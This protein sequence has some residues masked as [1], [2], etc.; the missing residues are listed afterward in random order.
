[1]IHE[2]GHWMN[3]FKGLESNRCS[4]IDQE[5]PK[6]VMQWCA[7]ECLGEREKATSGGGERP[8]CMRVWAPE[9]K[10]GDFWWTWTQVG[11]CITKSW[12][13]RWAEISTAARSLQG[14]SSDR[15]IHRGQAESG[16]AGLKREAFPSLCEI[17]RHW[18]LRGEYTNDIHDA[19]DLF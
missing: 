18:P 15:Q 6:S 10:L 2:P 11:S 13:M 19:P 5:S 4:S 17:S 12:I 1:M 9:N 8:A 7:R 3:Q 14:I 16:L